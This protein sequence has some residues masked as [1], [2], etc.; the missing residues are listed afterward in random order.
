VLD[1]RL[2][3]TI[4]NAMDFEIA[5]QFLKKIAKNNNREWFEKNKAHYLDLKSSFE[6]FVLDLLEEMIKFDESLAGLDPKKLLFRIYRDVRFSKDKRPYK[7]NLSAAFSS[8]GKGMEKP[9]YYFHVEP[10]DKSFVAIGLYAPPVENLARVRQEIDYNGDRLTKI[11]KDRSFK[12]YFSDFWLEDSLKTMP[13]GYS[14]DHPYIKWLKLKS[15]VVMHQFTD[16]QVM[17]KKFMK[18]LTAVLKEGK[19]INNF[20]N[21]AVAS[22]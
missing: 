8:A 3:L 11:F 19:S 5:F 12:K 17:D 4:Y 13:K 14:K 7:H 18:Q 21:D 9:G 10:G 16:K 22:A 6:Q 2:L 20:L 15:F 1:S